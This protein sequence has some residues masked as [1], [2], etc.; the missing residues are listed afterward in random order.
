MSPKSLLKLL[1]VSLII[2]SAGYFYVAEGKT[3]KPRVKV[4]AKEAQ[5]SAAAQAEAKTAPAKP[6]ETSPAAAAAPATTQTVAM[7]A[8]GA[9]ASLGGEE[10]AAFYGKKFER[11]ATV[12]KVVALTFDDGPY[13][14]TTPRV[15]EI[16]KAE[17]ITA[18]FF[19][20]GQSVQKYPEMAKVVAD[21]GHEIGCHTME[22]KNLA[23]Q[24]AAYIDQEI[25]GVAGFIEQATGKRP[26]VFRPPFGSFN[27]FV[28]QS[29]A[30]GKMVMVNWSVDTNDWRKG[31]T[32][33]SIQATCAKYAHNGA[34]VL[35]HDTHEKTI[36]ALPGVIK[37]LKAKGY[38]FVT[39]SQLIAEA[40]KHKVMPSTVAGGGAE[41]IPVAAHPA[42]IP[43]SKSGF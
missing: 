33:A 37:D 27:H 10:V 24:D 32:A 43:L 6:A 1:F 3:K 14:K 4:V 39:V 36:V 15:L 7:A 22:H 21:A 31:S 11:G 2:A 17:G 19:M 9:N 25:N 13:A 30:A 8:S 28:L 35:M 16:L 5:A 34:V 40:V 20:L 18:T 41:V 26:Q 29:C 12:A 23:R 42:S 38:Q